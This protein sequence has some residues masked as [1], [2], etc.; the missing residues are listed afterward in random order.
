MSNLVKNW[1]KEVSYKTHAEDIRTVD[2]EYVA[3]MQPLDMLLH[4]VALPMVQISCCAGT[5]SSLSMAVSRE[6]WQKCSW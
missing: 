5:T 2:A 4:D 6:G 1:E 3:C